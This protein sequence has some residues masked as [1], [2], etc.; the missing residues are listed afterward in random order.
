VRAPA[1]D[2]HFGEQSRPPAIDRPTAPAGSS[3]VAVLA[4]P[5]DEAP[6]RARHG[7]PVKRA[8]DLL[9]A[10]TVLLLALPLMAI[11]AL[12]I[13]LESP[14]PVLYRAER[15]GRGGRPM[16]MLKFRKM[17]R[18]A[19]G[20]KLTACRDPRLTRVGMVLACT[21]LDELPQLLNVL[22]GDMSL[23]GPRPEDPGFVAQRRA[24]YDEILKV[25]PGITGLSQIAF[26]EESR[27]LCQDDAVGD[28]LRR[29]LPQKC[30]LDR[31]YVR[32]VGLGTDMRILAWTIVAV[33][34]RRQVAVDRDTGRLCQRR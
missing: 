27:I 33:V 10:G 20:P 11:V 23:I 18:N 32:T 22:R 12:A 31:M 6:R 7:Q 8:L 1:L 16:R 3:D 34:L 9:V 2:A 5:W 14:G 26:A 29:I 13:M 30:A 21:K 4:P 28:Y 25:R 15:V 17:R 19:V 24:D